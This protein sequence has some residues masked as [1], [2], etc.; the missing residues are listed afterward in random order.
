MSVFPPTVYSSQSRPFPSSVSKISSHCRIPKHF[1]IFRYLLHPGDRI[2]ICFLGLL[3]TEFHKLGD[4][5]KNPE[6]YS[7][8][9]LEA[10]ILKLGVGWAASSSGPHLAWSGLFRARP[11]C[12]QVLAPVAV[13]SRSPFPLGLQLG[14]TELPEVTHIPQ[15]VAPLSSHHSS[16]NIL[17]TL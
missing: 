15:P 14:C 8:T 12:W 11:G 2:C 17:L 5:K 9:V 1:Y 13:G 10:G 6:I 4:L 3:I 16:S 7:P